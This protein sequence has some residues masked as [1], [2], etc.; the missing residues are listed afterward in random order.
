MSQESGVR[1][2][3]SGVR[4]QESG[5]RS[6]E[7]G[8]RERVYYFDFLRV[9]GVFAV[10]ILHIAASKWYSTDI[11]T[12]EWQVINFYDSAPVRWAVP[13]Y[14]MISG[15]LFLGRDIPI[16]RLYSKNILRI[17]TA[18]LFWS[19]IYAARGYIKTGNFIG[20]LKNFI[21]GPFHLWFLFM[22]TGLYIVIPFMRRIAESE[23]LTKYFLALSFI[24]VF[25][26]PPIITLIKFFAPNHG[27]FIKNFIN[28]FSP[29]LVLGYSGYFLLGY[30]LNKINISP[31]LTRFIYILGIIGFVGAIF[32]SVSASLIRNKPNSTFYSPLSINALFESIGIFVLFKKKFNWQSKIIRRLSQYS[33]GAYLVHSAGIMF[34]GKIG[35]DKL[36]LNPIISIPVTAIFVFVVSFIVSGVLNHI[37]VLKKYVV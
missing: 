11:N 8:V 17:V 15:A 18:F 31:R 33:F 5:V 30:Y 19:F 28:S 35:V 10:I 14:V 12:F 27:N 21:S 1:S 4:S 2:Q 23:L 34:A 32:M 36:I 26:L 24:F 20:M 13:V 7:S 37:P 9:L 3:E 16:K 22:L 25:M 29:Q 6:Q